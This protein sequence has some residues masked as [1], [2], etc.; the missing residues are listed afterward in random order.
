MNSF[1]KFLIASL[2]TLLLAAATAVVAQPETP[3]RVVEI[4]AKKFEFTPNVV[5]LKK[6]EPV[7]I[8]FTSTDRAHGLLVKAFKIDLDADLGKPADV[9]VTPHEAGTFA[10]ICDH[11]C[12]SGHG[13]MKMTFVVE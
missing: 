5:T 2:L 10:A 13:N 6:D 1:N 3:A 9:T 4:S 12:G 7:T 8:H 11:Y